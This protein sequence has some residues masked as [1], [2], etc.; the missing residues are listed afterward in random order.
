MKIKKSG[1]KKIL[2]EL[3]IIQKD[4]INY[5]F[6]TNNILFTFKK[7]QYN[8]IK[9]TIALFSKTLTIDRKKKLN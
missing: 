2:Q 8:K 5:F 4:G 7:N 9:K 1:F 6:Y 3:Y